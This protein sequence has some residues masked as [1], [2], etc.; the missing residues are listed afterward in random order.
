MLH[1]GVDPHPTS[2]SSDFF[3]RIS[4]DLPTEPGDRVKRHQTN[5][6][7]SPIFFSKTSWLRHF[8]VRKSAEAFF[9]P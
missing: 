2:P 9:A 6:C 7:N 4:S 1:R 5:V 3:R 8:R